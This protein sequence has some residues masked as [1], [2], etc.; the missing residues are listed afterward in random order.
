LVA[1]AFGTP[2]EAL[3]LTLTMGVPLAGAFL[4]GAGSV[5][6]VYV[7]L[8]AFDY[9][10]SMGYSNVEVVSHRVFEAV[11]PLRYILYTPT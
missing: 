5:G 2:L 10:R 1:A 8:I 3:L 9:L 11:P 6:L 4:M 7:Y